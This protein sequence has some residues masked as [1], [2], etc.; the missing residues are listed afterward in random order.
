[1]CVC[2]RACLCER[3]GTIFF[4]FLF[5]YDLRVVHDGR[6]GK[7]KTKSD[8]FIP[9]ID[10]KKSTNFFKR[11]E[12]NA[13]VHIPKCTPIDRSCFRN[14]FRCDLA[15]GGMCNSV[16]F[17]HIYRVIAPKKMFYG[18]KTFPKFNRNPQSDSCVSTR[19]F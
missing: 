15:H 5:A 3:G 13:P 7:Q 16:V 9:D 8:F 4:P 17:K 14:G 2:A 10:K 11:A 12:V 6:T 1:M 19:H 18:A